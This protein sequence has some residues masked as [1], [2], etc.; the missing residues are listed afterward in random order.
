MPNQ[1]RTTA[2]TVCVEDPTAPNR[3]RP[4]VSPATGE[5]NAGWS[6]LWAP[7]FP[8]FQPCVSGADGWRHDTM[9]RMTFDWL[10]ESGLCSSRYTVSWN[11]RDPNRQEASRKHDGGE[12]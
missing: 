4:I 10:D 7:R 5:C 8:A 3:L 9:Q 11:Y 2:I 1:V 12:D 6:Q